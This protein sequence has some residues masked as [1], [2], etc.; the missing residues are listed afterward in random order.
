MIVH[1]KCAAFEAEINRLI[2]RIAEL[3]EYIDKLNRINDT[4]RIELKNATIG[5][6]KEELI[7]EY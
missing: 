3:E 2:V 1:D 5:D 6:G 7:N 4:L